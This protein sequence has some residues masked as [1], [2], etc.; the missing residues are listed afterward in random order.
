MPPSCLSCAGFEDYLPFTVD[1][2]GHEPAEGQTDAD[3]GRRHAE[4]FLDLLRG[5]FLAT[6]SS[7]YVSQSARLAAPGTVFRSLARSDLVGP[8][9]NN[10]HGSI[11]NKPPIVLQNRYGAASRPS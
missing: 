9:R 10:P 8:A 3:M 4:I 11:R 5:R 7:A 2:F 6:Q 1:Y